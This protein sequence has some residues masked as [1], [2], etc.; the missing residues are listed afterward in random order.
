LIESRKETTVS[1]ETETQIATMLR[2]TEEA[3]AV[4]EREILDGVYDE[5]WPAW[6]AAYLIQNG[7]D[8]LTPGFDVE[9]LAARL[10]QLDEA[11]KKEEPASEWPDFYAARLATA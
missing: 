5:D 2:Q 9:T 3:H 11:Y 1:T 6:Y 7:L 8:D 4:F 10:K